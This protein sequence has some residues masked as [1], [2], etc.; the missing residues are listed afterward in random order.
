[1]TAHAYT[2]IEESLRKFCTGNRA[3]RQVI[4]PPEETNSY[5]AF[6][7]S[8]W[9]P[10]LRCQGIRQLANR[11]L[12]DVRSLVL[13]LLLLALTACNSFPEASFS[14]AAD[15]R[16]PRW[17]A[18]P[19][20]MKRSDLSVRMDYY[21]NPSGRTAQFTLAGPG[22]NI[23]AKAAGKVRG[24]APSQVNDPPSGRMQQY[25]LYEVVTVN[26]ITEIVEHRRLE[27]T[28]Y[29]TDDAAVWGKL[30]RP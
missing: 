8:Q 24:L 5:A 12:C 13:S 11:W 3:A 14:L 17:F 6:E 4:H 22:G 2:R 10:M 15:S 16:L 30:L 7:V 28:F 27:P 21:V 26:G 29:L 1:M 18:V 20:G 23:V 19:S 25:P 9:L